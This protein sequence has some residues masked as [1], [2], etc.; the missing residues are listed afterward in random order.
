MKRSKLIFIF[1]VLSMVAAICVHRWDDWFINLAEPAYEADPLPHHV[2]ITYG[3]DASTA[4][5][6]TWRTDL[7]EQ[8]YSIV[9]VSDSALADTL[10]IPV[11]SCVVES[12]AG[13]AVYYEAKLTDLRPDHYTFFIHSDY[14]EEPVPYSFT[15]DDLADTSAVSF[16][17][18]GDIQDSEGVAARLLYSEA[19][20]IAPEASYFAYAGD[21]VARPADACWNVWFD[22]MDTAFS[23]TTHLIP[24]M[25]IPGDDEYMRGIHRTIDSRWQHIFINPH[26][27]P[28]RFKG[29]TY[30]VDFPQLRMVMIDTNVLQLFSDYTILMTW[31][32][33]VL[34]EAAEM[35][36]W[37]VVV[38]HHPVYSAGMQRDN[39]LIYLS[40]KR[41]LLT[42]DVVFA[43][44]DHSYQ[45]L[46]WENE[47]TRITDEPA[48]I[49]ISSFADSY[50]PKCREDAD[51]LGANH[52][53]FSH[54]EVVD[55]LLNVKT[56]AVYAADSTVLYDAF[57]LRK[58]PS[59][60][61]VSGIGKFS[62]LPNYR[63][64]KLLIDGVDSLMQE[65]LEMPDSYH[66]H[67]DKIRVRRF[68]NRRI[69]RE[70]SRFSGE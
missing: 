41:A 67:M 52:M 44:H 40:M 49:V 9:L 11:H 60:W 30:F 28:S 37:T 61:P 36:K 10:R 38:M 15:I 51:R 56:Y 32:E 59:D 6:I 23:G 45:R 57:S 24:H 43:G 17:V 46:V 33:R 21:I 50:L 54:V 18:F 8:D 12:R 19:T 1:L 7:P 3:Q 26:N 66:E 53:Y 35:G 34:R 48:Y 29:N 22:A 2:L 68:I 58:L 4:R 47:E 27:G 42:A 55:S 14:E 70:K 64:D 16:L 39:P 31:T 20:R 65:D 62:L 13:S 5:T 25:A 69:A 63:L